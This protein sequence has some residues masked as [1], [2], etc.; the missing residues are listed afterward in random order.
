MTPN[1]PEYSARDGG[2][3]KRDPV[4]EPP[5][6]DEADRLIGETFQGFRFQ[7]V[8]GQGPRSIVYGG[9][10][11]ALRRPVAIKMLERTHV[12]DEGQVGDFLEAGRKAARLLHPHVVGIYDV[13]SGGDVHFIVQERV[14]GNSLREAI[15]SGIVLTPEEMIH[16]G[17]AA[18]DALSLAHEQGIFHG[19][20]HPG[21]VFLG[22]EG[23]LRVGDFGHLCLLLD[24]SARFSLDLEHT[25]FLAAEQLRGDDP[26]VATDVFSLGA[27]LFFSVTGA[28]PFTEDMQRQRLEGVCDV[29]ALPASRM[30]P[31]I[32]SVLS[33][34][35]SDMLASDPTQRPENMAAVA[36]RLS[37]TLDA[38]EREAPYAPSDVVREQTEKLGPP[39]RRKYKRLRADMDVR[40]TRQEA[41]ESTAE[42]LFSRLGNFS[43]NGAFVSTPNP[44]T[45]GT[46][47]NL[48]FALESRGS[49]IHVL[50]IV[51]WVNDDPDDPGMG[52]Q[53]LEVSTSNRRD[54]REFIDDRVAME[55]ARTLTRTPLHKSILEVIVKNWG[56][57]VSADV[58]AQATGAG[59]TMLLKTLP[60]FEKQGLIRVLHRSVKCV[61]PP[62]RRI[63]QALKEAAVRR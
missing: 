46:I 18:T 24:R 22:Q 3:S 2:P 17:I 58:L 36:E 51:R 39:V 62:S 30:N 5:L 6:H 29:E 60:E 21:N 11:I 52:I 33:D 10:Q 59:S 42:M 15:A 16:A 57:L 28:P 43:E 45:V 25:V 27:I 54:L 1:Q 55:M 8:I 19:D 13:V 44:L 12:A 48:D 41:T 37:A 63:A 32:P 4:S 23:M 34:A 47:V 14:A 50:G 9:E 49:R 31:V 40:I 53:F 56:K 20:L 26:S 35:L 38:F 61:R 7:Q